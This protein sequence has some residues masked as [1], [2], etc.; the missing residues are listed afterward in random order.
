[1]RFAIVRQVE[2]AVGARQLGRCGLRVAAPQVARHRAVEIDPDDGGARQ[3]GR[4]GLRVSASQVA[5]HRAVEA[6]PDDAAKAVSRSGRAQRRGGVEPHDAAKGEGGA[7]SGGT[8][9]C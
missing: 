6:D 9:K 1:M 5:R 3:L 8:V 2:I 4:C 7:I